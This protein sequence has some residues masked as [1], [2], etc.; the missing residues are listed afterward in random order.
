M[1]WPS[2]RAQNTRGTS[3]VRGDEHRVS[4]DVV[5]VARQAHGQ[6]G[7]DVRKFDRRSDAKKGYERQKC[8]ASVPCYI[9]VW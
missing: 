9:E 7:C 5:D 8:G 1:L 4:E 6:S 2:I 3:V